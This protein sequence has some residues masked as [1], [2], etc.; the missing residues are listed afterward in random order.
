VSV[1]IGE[2]MYSLAIFFVAPESRSMK[3]TLNELSMNESFRLSGAHT[4]CS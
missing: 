1:L 2:Y 3:Y 4:G